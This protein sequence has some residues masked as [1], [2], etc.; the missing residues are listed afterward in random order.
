MTFI[1]V[2]DR[3]T[4]GKEGVMVQFRPVELQRSSDRRQD[5]KRDV[6]GHVYKNKAFEIGGCEPRF[7]P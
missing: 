6:P 3:L 7:G 2:L 1:E 5:L 4:D